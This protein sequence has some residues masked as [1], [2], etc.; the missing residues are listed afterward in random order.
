MAISEYQTGG[1]GKPV[2]LPSAQSKH[3]SLPNM[4]VGLLMSSNRLVHC[5]SILGSAAGFVMNVVV[6]LENVCDAW[7]FRILCMYAHTVLGIC[8]A[9]NTYIC[10]TYLGDYLKAE[11][12]DSSF[13]P[14]KQRGDPSGWA[15]NKLSS[16]AEE[17]SSKT[18]NRT[19]Y[20]AQDLQ[21]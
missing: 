1:L 16:L 3:L 13:I 11:L 9:R 17:P 19:I 4:Y 5:R 6:A 20:G 18:E 21:S 7:I 10:T 2:V 8:K 12:V 14:G 15:S